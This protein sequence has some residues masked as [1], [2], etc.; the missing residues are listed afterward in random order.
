MSI[1]GAF[2]AAILAAAALCGGAASSQAEAQAGAPYKLTERDMKVVKAGVRDAFRDPESARFGGFR[3]SRSKADVIAV[4]GLVNAKNG[5]GGY[6]GETPFIGT[7][8][9]SGGSI[10]VIMV[11]FTRSEII[12]VSRVCRSAG[13]PLP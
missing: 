4:C 7:I 9:G 5:Y 13:A 11:A 8:V 12:S 2:R 10:Y 1:I 6:T 3:A